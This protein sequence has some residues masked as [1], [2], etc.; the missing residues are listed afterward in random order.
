MY[1]LYARNQSF[2]EIEYI[3]KVLLSKIPNL[4]KIPIDAFNDFDTNENIILYFQI[5]IKACPKK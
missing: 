5:V 1:F 3:E 2:F 4:E